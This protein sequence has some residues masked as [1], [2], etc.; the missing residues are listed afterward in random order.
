MTK[1]KQKGQVR[2]MSNI[3]DGYDV[4]GESPMKN[5]K[6]PLTYCLAEMAGTLSV[7]KEFLIEA[8]S[9]L[10]ALTSSKI[11]LQ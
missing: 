7:C 8:I 11:S 5:N 3:S 9:Q 1:L 4:T 10:D 2:K 6:K